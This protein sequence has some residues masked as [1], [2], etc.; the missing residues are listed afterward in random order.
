MF[1]FRSAL[2]C[3]LLWALSFVSAFSQTVITTATATPP[4]CDGGHRTVPP[5]GICTS[6]SYILNADFSISGATNA[7]DI[8]GDN[9]TLDLNGFSVFNFTQASCT[10]GT[11]RGNSCTGAQGTLVGINI[12]GNNVEVKNGSVRNINGTGISSGE[13]ALLHDLRVHDN[14]GNGVSF[15]QGQ[16]RNVSST[17]NNGAGIIVGRALVD[18]AYSA[19]NNSFGIEGVDYDVLITNSTVQANGGPG[20]YLLAGQTNNVISYL[21][22]GSGFQA[23]SLGQFVSSFAYANTSDGFYTGGAGGGIINSLGSLNGGYGFDLSSS[24]C[25]SDIT[26]VSNT[27]GTVTGGAAYGTGTICAH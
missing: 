10:S 1:N 12:T 8:A 9:I 7:I 27:T 16:V 4:G 2:V 14:N 6:G 15:S 19:Y 24:T 20:V 13:T 17:N 11:P 26:T 25:Y 18:A 23:A 21:N 3:A 5:V 22:G